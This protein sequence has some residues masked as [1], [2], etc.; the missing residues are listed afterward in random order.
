[1]NLALE[2]RACRMLFWAL[3]LVFQICGGPLWGFSVGARQASGGAA[4]PS[5]H[6]DS[7]HGISWTNGFDARGNVVSRAGS[8]GSTQ[9]LAWDAL[10][11]LRSVMARHLLFRPGHGKRLESGLGPGE[12]GGRRQVHIAVFLS[13]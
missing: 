1:M 2:P 4:S 6:A 8:D 13:D 10:G 11:R 12:R 9:Q 7:V 5:C 3:L